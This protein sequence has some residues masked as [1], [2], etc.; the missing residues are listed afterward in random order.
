MKK[1]LLYTKVILLLCFTITVYSQQTPVFSDYYYNTILINPAHAGFYQDVDITA[2]N[3]GSLSSIEGAPQS[4][5]VTTNI[6]FRSEKVGLGFG[7]INDQIGVTT[8]NQFFASYAYKVIFNDDYAQSKSWNYNPTVFSFGITAGVQL[9]N[10]DLLSLNILD[11]PNF[12]N[13]IN[14]TI[15]TIGAGFLY[16]KNRIYFGASATNLLGDSLSSEDNINI[17][18]PFFFHGGYRFFLTRFQ[19]VRVTPNTLVRYVSGAPLQ[20]DLNVTINYKNKFEA[21]LGYRS[22]SSVNLFFGLYAFQNFRIL[23]NY[24]ANAVDTPINNVLGVLLSY[25]LGT[26][27][28]FN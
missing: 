27:F 24:T 19:E 8:S 10:E 17:E 6:P 26:G 12:Q 16:N 23:F 4:F 20:V 18:S 2:G 1:N 25:R 11:D 22:N 3:R 7:F 21:G 13:N 15:P 5:S 14:T 28:K 9:F